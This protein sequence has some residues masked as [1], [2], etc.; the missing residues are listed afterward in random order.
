MF[1]GAVNHNNYR[2]HK[3]LYRGR[4]NPNN[5]DILATYFLTH[6]YTNWAQVTFLIVQYNN[7]YRD[8]GTITVL[9]IAK[10]VH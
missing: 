2:H 6:S 1:D 4:K 10:A 9:L 3:T 8:K 7:Y 5:C